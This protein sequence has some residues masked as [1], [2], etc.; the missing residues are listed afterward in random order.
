MKI[1]ILAQENDNHTAPL[2]WA[3][4]QTGSNETE[5]PGGGVRQE[6]R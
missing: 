3:L 5:S 6:V 1:V 2:K 4:E